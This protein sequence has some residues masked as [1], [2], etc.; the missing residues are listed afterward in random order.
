MFVCSAFSLQLAG[1]DFFSFFWL[2]NSLIQN[3]LQELVPRKHKQPKPTCK[4]LW[5]NHKTT[6]NCRIETYMAITIGKTTST[7]ERTKPSRK[8]TKQRL[9]QPQLS[10]SA[11]NT[12]SL[13]LRKMIYQG[14]FQSKH[15]SLYWTV[16]F[17]FLIEWMQILL[18]LIMPPTTVRASWATPWKILLSL[19]L[20]RK[21]VAANINS[22]VLLGKLTCSFQWV[23]RARTQVR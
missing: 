14:I 6:A 1:Y 4:K 20:R 21:H 12:I 10:K 23:A 16:Y 19:S 22:I 8:A 9:F 17:I 5:A 3:Y 7:Y 13:T 18:S 11:S 2:I 15:L